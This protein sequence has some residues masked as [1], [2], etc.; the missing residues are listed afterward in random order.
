MQIVIKFKAQN[1]IINFSGVP[2]C[3]C[4]GSGDPHYKTFDGQWIH[5]MGVCKYTLATPKKTSKLPHFSVEVKNEHR[6]NTRVSYTRLVDLKLNGA[7]IRLLPGSKLSV[8]KYRNYSI[9]RLYTCLN[10]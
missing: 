1:A 2:G 7:T 5:F 3:E 9:T 8:S 6:G 10:W 4:A